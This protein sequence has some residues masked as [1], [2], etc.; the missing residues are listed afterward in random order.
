MI[1][2]KDDSYLKRYTK[3][4]IKHYSNE[5]GLTEGWKKACQGYANCLRLVKDKGGLIIEDDTAFKKGWYKKF[6]QYLTFIH[7]K[8]FILSL[9][10]AMDGSVV[11]PNSK[12][13]SVQLFLYRAN[14]RREE[15]GPPTAL[16]I[17]W[18]DSH[19]VYYPPT[20]PFDDMARHIEKFG[21]QQSSMHDILVGYYM[22]RKLYPIYIASPFLAINIGAH[23]TS[24]GFIPDR[25]DDFTDWDYSGA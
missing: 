20:L 17:L 1:S 25:N 8:R 15:N 9:G 11:N 24:V 16:L 10:K 5:E 23:N 3:G 22:F 7:D 4:F 14:L 6:L 13:P 18:Y 19:A 12:I 2:G 21:V